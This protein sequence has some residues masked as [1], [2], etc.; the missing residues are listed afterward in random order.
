M[1][2][3]SG[4]KMDL[5]KWLN[6]TL[7]AERVLPLL[8]EQYGIRS[9]L[10][11]MKDLFIVKYDARTP[12]KQ[13]RLDTHQDSSQLSFNIALTQYDRDYQGGGT[14][15]DILGGGRRTVKIERGAMLTHPSKLFHSGL[16]ITDG[17]RYLLVG[18]VS[19]EKWRGDLL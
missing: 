16:E 17:Q 15:F 9:H 19:V 11:T 2:F 6:E 13:R 5:S 10:M 14:K 4:K 3:D 12:G 8:S 18:F 7:L 1:L